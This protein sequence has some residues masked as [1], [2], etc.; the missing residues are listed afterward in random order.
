VREKELSHVITWSLAG[1]MVAG[2]EAVVFTW[3]LI[4]VA[5]EEAY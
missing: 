4:M 3:L 5:K 2:G 1:V